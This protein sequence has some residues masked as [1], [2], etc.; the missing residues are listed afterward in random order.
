MHATHEDEGDSLEHGT[1]WMR[2]ELV[3][4][5]R[6]LGAMVTI[7]LGPGVV[8]G[9]AYGLTHE[10]GDF[11]SMIQDRSFL[12]NGAYEAA[13]LGLFLLALQHRGWSTADFRLRIGWESTLQGF[14][15]LAISYLGLMASGVMLHALAQIFHHVAW[16]DGALPKLGALHKGSIHLSWVVIFTFTIVNAFYE[17]LVYMGL[18][19]N[20]CAAKAGVGWAVAVTIFARMLIHT[21]QGTSHVV[22]IGVWALIFTLGYVRFKRVWPL[23]LAHTMIDL[24]SLSALKLMFG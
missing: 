23:V 11:M 1:R 10:T 9:A 13:M 18:L 22:Q 17:E 8:L 15:L 19:F 3:A 12:A 5:W 6:W 14:G 24:V 16:I 4:S 20:Q 7:M 2:P 21:Y